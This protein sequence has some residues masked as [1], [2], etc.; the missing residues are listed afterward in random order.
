MTYE[1][2][3]AKGGLASP[4][5]FH[6]AGEAGNHGRAIMALISGVVLVVVRVELS[7]REKLCG[8]AT[9]VVGPEGF[10]PS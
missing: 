8:V 6:T 3:H 1:L 4:F 10:E 7:R 5:C 9:S 2:H